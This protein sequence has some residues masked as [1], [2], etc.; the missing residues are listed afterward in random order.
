[1]GGPLINKFIATT[2]VFTS[3]AFAAFAQANVAFIFVC[4]T[5]AKNQ[6]LPVGTTLAGMIRGQANGSAPD[7]VWARGK[8]SQPYPVWTVFKN[9]DVEVSSEPGKQVLMTCK[10]ADGSYTGYIRERIPSRPL[11]YAIRCKKVQGSIG[12]VSCVKADSN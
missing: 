8:A 10:F 1:M 3:I 12:R 2:I 11:K 6:W 9:V 4:P 7:R 5:Q